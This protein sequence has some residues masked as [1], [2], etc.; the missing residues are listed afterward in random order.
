MTPP[1]KP[2][3]KTHPFQILQQEY[4]PHSS[5]SRFIFCLHVCELVSAASIVAASTLFFLLRCRLHIVGIWLGRWG[6]LW[7][8]VK[9]GSAS[10]GTMHH[11]HAQ[12][13]SSENNC[14]LCV[15]ICY[16]N[17]TKTSARKGLRLLAADVC[18]PEFNQGKPHHCQCG[19]LPFENVS[20]FAHTIVCSSPFFSCIDFYLVP[21]GLKGCVMW[22]WLWQ[23][24]IRMFEETWILHPDR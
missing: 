7:C 2:A 19:P 13:L 5:T 6:L 22:L 12:S 11:Q 8:P 17:C 1:R 24:E 20:C 14:V 18:A 4:E 15:T 16:L 23:L 10:F 21:R 9:G 3:A